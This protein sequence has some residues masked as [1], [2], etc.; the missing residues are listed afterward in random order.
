MKD[1]TDLL[2][3]ALEHP[4]RFSDAELQELLSDPS[5][6]ELYELM[7][8]SA[9]ALTPDVEPDV[10]QAW[11]RFSS[12]HTRLRPIRHRSIFR[13]ALRRPAAAAIITIAASIAVAAAT[14]SITRTLSRPEPAPQAS[15]TSVPAEAT[16]A[17]EV[18]NI[19]DTTAIAMA[20][21]PEIIV[22]QNRTLEDIIGE[23]GRY[24]D[25]TPTFRNASAR[26]LRLYFKWNQACTLAEVI[27]QLNSFEQIHITLN[28]NSLTID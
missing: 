21:E 3:E 17:E 28:N 19:P 26:A 27:E 16:H 6:R 5:T 23:T 9:D 12:R 22:F 11:S 2:F 10:D 1:N 24:Y 4:D 25:A 7:C 13:A 14:I 20:A 18:A 8:K 15:T